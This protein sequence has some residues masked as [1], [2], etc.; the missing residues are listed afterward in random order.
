MSART[1]PLQ[2]RRQA[3]RARMA[4]KRE[5]ERLATRAVVY[6]ARDGRGRIVGAR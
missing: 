3:K 1:L 6:I 5:L 4:D 2:R